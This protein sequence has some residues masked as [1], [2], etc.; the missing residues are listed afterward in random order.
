MKIERPCLLCGQKSSSI[1][2][3]YWTTI[4]AYCTISKKLDKVINKTVKT[5]CV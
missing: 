3:N 5:G 1:N 4:L 2:M